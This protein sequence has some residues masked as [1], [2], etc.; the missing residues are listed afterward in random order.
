MQ[1]FWREFYGNRAI[2]LVDNCLGGNFPLVQLSSGEVISGEIIQGAVILWGNY[3]GGN[4]SRGKF[5][6]NPHEVKV[7]RQWNLVINRTGQEKYF[8]EKI[9][10]KIRQESYFQISFQFLKKLYLKKKQKFC[11]LDFLLFYS[12]YDQ[13]PLPGCLYFV[14]YWAI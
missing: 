3:P 2:F 11:S 14:R 9:M 6:Q 13:I 12:I 4:F 10:Q 1:L 7:T 5:F 8:S